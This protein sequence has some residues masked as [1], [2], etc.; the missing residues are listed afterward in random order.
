MA[1]LLT[2]R[3]ILN[4][5]QSKQNVTT[6]KLD[7][8]NALILHEGQVKRLENE[9]SDLDS[10]PAGEQATHKKKVGQIEDVIKSLKD[11]I[12]HIKARIV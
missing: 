9:L 2:H 4:F 11:V 7:L 5:T 3:Q 10:H 12:K 6:I 1:S 8:T